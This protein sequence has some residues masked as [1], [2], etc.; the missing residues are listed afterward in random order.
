MGAC[1][2]FVLSGGDLEALTEDRFV[3][4]RHLKGA[5]RAETHASEP[6]EPS[7]AYYRAITSLYAGT[8]PEAGRLS[9]KVV[10]PAFRF[11]LDLTTHRT[12]KTHFQ[13]LTAWAR[14]SLP[15]KMALNTRLAA[16]LWD[17]CEDKIR[18]NTMTNLK[19][20][21][22]FMTSDFVTPVKV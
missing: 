4:N 9:G 22:L 5:I 16:K 13:Y 1:I 8:A 12:R 15:S 11:V 7:K 6:P 14:L 19:E 10:Y 20:P 2:C 21:H 17:W 3:D 18:E